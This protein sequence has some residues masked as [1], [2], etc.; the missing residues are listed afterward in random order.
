MFLFS[1]SFFPDAVVIEELHWYQM[2]ANLIDKVDKNIK[3][4]EAI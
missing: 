2:R 4:N 3:F 1:Y